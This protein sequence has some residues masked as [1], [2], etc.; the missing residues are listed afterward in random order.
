MLDFGS[1][2]TRLI[3]RRVREA[4]VYSEIRGCDAGGEAIAA[5]ATARQIVLSGGPDSVTGSDWLRIPEAVF[6]AGVPVLGLCYGMQ[7]M[8][9]HFGGAVESAKAREFGLAEV[10]ARGHSEL[11]RDIE[12]RAGARPVRVCSTCG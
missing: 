4:G 3:A 6:A 1:Q 8:A 10:R 12:D 7:A 5:F 2:Y 11:L 9:A